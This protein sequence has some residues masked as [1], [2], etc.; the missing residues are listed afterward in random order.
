MLDAENVAQ[1]AH[2]LRNRGFG[3]SYFAGHNGLVFPEQ[4]ASD[5]LDA[6]CH[7]FEVARGNLRNPIE[8][9]YEAGE[10]RIGIRLVLIDAEAILVN[11][12]VCEINLL[13]WRTVFERNF[14]HR[15]SPEECAAQDWATG[16]HDKRF[17]YSV[18]SEKC[19]RPIASEII[20]QSAP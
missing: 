16:K 1:I 18:N 20:P 10:N 9:F 19:E 4:D 5:C 12:V 14:S 13:N 2:A 17:G 11:R 3:H 7:A 6:D 8:R 15:S